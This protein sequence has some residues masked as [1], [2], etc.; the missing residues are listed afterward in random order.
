MFCDT[1]IGI[2]LFVKTLF[3]PTNSQFLLSPDMNTTV[4]NAKPGFL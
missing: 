1:E 2:M 4:T 3:L